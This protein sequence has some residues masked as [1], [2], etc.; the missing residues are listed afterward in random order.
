MSRAGL[1]SA[2]G[3]VIL[4]LITVATWNLG[5]P[6]TPAETQP[7]GAQLFQ[8]KGCASCH[9]GPDTA[10]SFDS[11]FPSLVAASEWANDRRPGLTAEDYLT[12]SIA[13]PRAFISPEFQPGHAGPTNAMPQL[14]ITS[15]EIDA[16]IDYLLQRSER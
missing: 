1:W 6:S 10:A 16:L 9:A 11:G 13:A 15:D 3:A 14:R 8:A 2:I 5:N 12:E 7:D 4:G